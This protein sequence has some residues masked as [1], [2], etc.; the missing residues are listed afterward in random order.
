[1][2]DGYMGA[3]LCLDLDRR[4]RWTW[5]LPPELKELFG[6]GKGFGAKLLFDLLP[7]GADPLGP[8]NVLMFLAGPLTGTSAPSMRACVVTKSP[9]TGIYL[10][11]FFGGRFGPEIRYAGYDGIILFGQAQEPVYVSVRDSE[12]EIRPAGRI[13]GRDALSANQ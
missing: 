9:L 13:W 6:G 3:L 11:S 4:T 8:D 2:P 12:V 5:E 10:D 1:M 7:P